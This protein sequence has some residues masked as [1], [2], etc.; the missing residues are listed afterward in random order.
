MKQPRRFTVSE[1]LLRFKPIMEESHR[2][3]LRKWRLRISTSINTR[4]ITEELFSGGIL[5]QN[6]CEEIRAQT[7]T[8][9]KALY[10]VD[11]LPRR[12][13]Q[14]FPMFLQ[15]LQHSGL[16]ELANAIHSELSGMREPF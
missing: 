15:A 6:D 12:G 9:Y 3:V 4:R 10:L 7:T 1:K 11:L 16:I 14:A 13:S 2:K 5:D 8:Q